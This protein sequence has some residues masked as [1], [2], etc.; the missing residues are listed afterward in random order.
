AEGAPAGAALLRPGLTMASRVRRA[1][2][3]A[4]I[5]AALAAQRFAGFFGQEL[6]AEAAILAILALSLD[7]LA[8][9]GLISFGQAGLFGIGCYAFGGLPVISGLS[10]T[11]ALPPPLPARALPAPAVALF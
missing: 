1:I 5:V 2:G 8:T 7:L 3:I 9:C 6:I 4:Q 10:P 11:P